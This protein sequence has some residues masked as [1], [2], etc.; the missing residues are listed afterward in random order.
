MLTT[1]FY[2]VDEFCKCF[3]KE[4]QKNMISNDHIKSFQSKMSLAEIMTIMIY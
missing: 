4:A 1:I 3:E 2:Y